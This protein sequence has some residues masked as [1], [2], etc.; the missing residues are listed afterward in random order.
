MLW[1]IQ[2]WQLE[3]T[4]REVRE[5]LGV[6][7]QRQWSDQAIARTTPALMGLYA[8]IVVLAHSLSKRG[9]LLP[10]QTAWYTKQFPTF[11]DALAAVRYGVN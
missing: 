5:H 8:L 10:R 3:V 1:F 6:E 7:M 2:R 4:Y 11:S 9:K